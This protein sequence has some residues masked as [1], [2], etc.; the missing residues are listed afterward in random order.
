MKREHK[1]K[2]TINDLDSR[3]RRS[4]RIGSQKNIKPEKNKGSREVFNTME[5][6][7]G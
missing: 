1:M 6:I 4:R 3:G 7:Y 5:G 2:S